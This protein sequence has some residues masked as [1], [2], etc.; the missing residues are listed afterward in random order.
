MSLDQCLTYN[1]EACKEL[2]EHVLV[3]CASSS[4]QR[5]LFGDP[6]A[7]SQ[8]I[9]ILSFSSLSGFQQCCVLFERKQSTCTC[10][11]VNVDYNSC[12]SRWFFIVSLSQEKDKYYMVYMYTIHVDQYSV[13]VTCNCMYMY[14]ACATV[15]GIVLRVRNCIKIITTPTPSEEW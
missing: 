13:I 10:M 12:Q 2:V 15:C 1:C 8:S 4:S 5:Q 14:Y 11:L 9:C 7:S 6:E 3:E